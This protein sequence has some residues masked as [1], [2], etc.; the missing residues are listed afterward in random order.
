MPSD[1][2]IDKIFRV[3]GET[4]YN[5]KRGFSV[6]IRNL[7]KKLTPITR[8]IWH[9]TRVNKIYE[10]GGAPV[11]GPSM[12]GAS[13]IAGTIADDAFAHAGEVPLHIQPKGLVPDL[14]RDGRYVEYR[15]RFIEDTDHVV[16]TRD[17]PGF[18]RQVR[19]V[20]TSFPERGGSH[21]V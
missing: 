14:A 17:H 6:E 11:G 8:E 18:L 1:G 2:S 9:S 7:V 16:E 10:F 3:V 19:K 21:F 13:P 4:H 15:D 12:D 20:N 5:V